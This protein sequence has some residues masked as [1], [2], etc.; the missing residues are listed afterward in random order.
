MSDPGDTN[1]VQHDPDAWAWCS[2]CERVFQVRAARDVDAAYGMRGDQCP[3]CDG[4]GWD[5]DLFMYPAT[6]AAVRL[7]SLPPPDALAHGDVV[8]ARAINL[9]ALNIESLV[10]DCEQSASRYHMIALHGV[11]TR[12]PEP[13]LLQPCMVPVLEDMAAMHAGE[14]AKVRSWATMTM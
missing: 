10:D 2:C 11:D 6:S 4:A 8:P 13:W 9:F 12:L 3:F 5:M 7:S 14:A 1:Q